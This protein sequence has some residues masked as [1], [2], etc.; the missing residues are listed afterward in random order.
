MVHLLA[1]RSAGLHGITSRDFAALTI[2]DRA[3]ASQFPLDIAAKHRNLVHQLTPKFFR[4]S[5]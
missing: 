3:L 5:S 4:S 1:L 2:V